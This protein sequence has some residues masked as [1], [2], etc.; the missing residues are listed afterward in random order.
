MISV[1]IPVLNEEAAL[2][3]LIPYL[4]DA[5]EGKSAELVFIDGGSSDKTVQV[6]REWGKTIY[7]SPLNGRASQ[8]N[9]GAEKCNGNILYFLHADSFPPRDFI[10][11]ILNSIEKGFI[12]GC[13]RLAFKPEL[14]LLKLYAW[15]TRFDVDLFRFGDQSLFV[16]R[17]V[18]EKIG[19]FDQSLKVMEDQQI[20]VNLKKYGKYKVM[21]NSII[22]SSR[23]YLKVG[24]LKL[25][26]IFTI[27][28]IFFYLGVSQT[29]MS[30]FYSKQVQ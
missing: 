4:H 27:I 13:Y 23:K 10:Q 2:K 6:C 26:L 21:N 9:F 25:Q 11:D 24:V 22:T 16:K 18:F 14:P 7:I 28:V 15:F 17:K 5:I 29:V 30:D 20:V 1:I 8:M 19:G 3:K 12:A